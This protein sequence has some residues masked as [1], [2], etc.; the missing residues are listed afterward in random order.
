MKILIALCALAACTHAQVSHAGIHDP[1]GN[2]VLFTHDQGHGIVLVGPS[3]VV[4]KGGNVQL[5]A[6]QAALAAKFPPLPLHRAKRALNL[7]LAGPSGMVYPDGRLVQFSHAEADNIASIGPSGIVRKD[8]LNTQ[9]GARKKRSLP[10]VGPSGIVYPDGRQV[11]FSQAEADNI[12]V[13]GPSGIVRKDGKNT[14]LRK[15]RSTKCLIGPSG[16]LC[17]GAN[18]VQ[19]SKHAT[20]VVEGP[21]GIVFSTGENIQI[22]SRRKR[23]LSKCLQGPSGVVCPSGPIQFPANAKLVEAGPSGIVFSTG[24]NIQLPLQE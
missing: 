5:T 1:D 8:G 2:H 22:G 23:S 18:P 13:V 24:E 19:F 4:S 3:G 11:Q 6:G 21:S 7:P 17:P 16:V 10:V 9:F 20:P 12:A 14:Q 15:K